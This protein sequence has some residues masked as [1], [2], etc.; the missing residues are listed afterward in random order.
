[1]KEKRN[2]NQWSVLFFSPVLTWRIILILLSFHYLYYNLLVLHKLP[3][4]LFYL[5]TQ[6]N[7][8][9]RN[10]LLRLNLCIKH[11][12]VFSFSSFFLFC[13]FV[14]IW[15]HLTLQSITHCHMTY[16]SLVKKLSTCYNTMQYLNAKLRCQFSFHHLIASFDL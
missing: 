9:C 16:N 2:W 12:K 14:C 5:K 10:L 3:K 4:N 11:C 6:R 8:K 7:I 13:L 15:W 1:M